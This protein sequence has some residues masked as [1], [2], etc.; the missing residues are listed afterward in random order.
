[1]G[2]RF[3]FPTKS[4]GEAVPEPISHRLRSHPLPS[5]DHHQRPTAQQLTRTD[6]WRGGRPATP[7]GR[8][9]SRGWSGKCVC[10]T[11]KTHEDQCRN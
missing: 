2:S 9:S 3:S 6:L 7:G 1:M 5:R 11:E 8:G 4:L 10:G